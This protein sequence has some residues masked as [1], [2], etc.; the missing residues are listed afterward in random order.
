MPTPLAATDLHAVFAYTR[1]GNKFR[2]TQPTAD[3][4]KAQSEWDAFDDPRHHNGRVTVIGM[5]IVGHFAVRSMDD[6]GWNTAPEPEAVQTIDLDPGH[7]VTKSSHRPLQAVRAYA[8]TQGVKARSGGWL[9]DENGQVIVQGWSSWIHTN[10]A[11]LRHDHKVV[12]AALAHHFGIT[13]GGK[14]AAIA[15]SLG[16]T[17]SAGLR[18]LDAALP[19]PDQ[20][21]RPG[22]ERHRWMKACTDAGVSLGES[23]ADFTTFSQV[24]P[25]L[26]ERGLLIVSG[27][28][29]GPKTYRLTALGRQV[30]AA[31]TVA[32]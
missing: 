16:K 24:A 10:V 8:A 14:P 13:P 9:Y 4:H 28:A 15:R 3:W 21:I 6:P 5:E 11:H 19:H 1:D 18:I 2:L 22:H 23:A 20:T 32:S 27:V 25:A 30:A 12:A 17:Q 31:L 7:F 29:Y 26:A